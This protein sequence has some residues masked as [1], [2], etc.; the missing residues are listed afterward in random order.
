MNAI[1]NM[2]EYLRKKLIE[3]NILATDWKSKGRGSR[4]K[5]VDPNEA[6]I[7]QLA[8]E[9]DQALKLAVEHETVAKAARAEIAQLHTQL[10]S[11]PT[12]AEVIKNFIVD[13]LAEVAARG[14][15]I[16]S[17]IPPV[18]LPKEPET[19][20]RHNPEPQAESVRKPKIALVGGKPNTHAL[21]HEAMKDIADMRYFEASS[22]N[23][24]GW[25]ESLKAF[26]DPKFGRVVA[27]T[28]VLTHVQEEGLKYHN[29]PFTRVSVTGTE[30][31]VESLKRIA[32]ELQRGV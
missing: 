19:L 21:V 14:R 13:I 16:G 28:S 9:R 10:R 23:R 22:A 24:G 26:K 17:T 25:A 29:I 20:P 18:P 1:G 32:E 8:D 31:L 30:A 7:N 6:R 5:P 3:A 15:A 27:W 12:E 11:Q 2:P 4:S